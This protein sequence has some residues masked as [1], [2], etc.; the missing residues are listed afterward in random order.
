[1]N[2]YSLFIQKSMQKYN[3]ITYQYNYIIYIVIKLEF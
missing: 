1:M 3:F 2:I